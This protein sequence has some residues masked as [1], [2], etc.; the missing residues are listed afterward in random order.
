MPLTFDQ[1]QSAI[2]QL[3]KHFQTNLNLYHAPTYKEARV[4]LEFIDE[5]FVNLGWDVYSQERSTPQYPQ[6][7]VEPT[8]EST[9]DAAARAPDYLFRIGKETKL[10][11]EA[12]KPGVS[13]E[14]DTRPAYQ[15]RSYAFSAKL[16]LSI[17]TDL[18]RVGGL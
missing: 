15:V 18:R 6:V 13:I 3:V 2:N 12:K 8:L 4:R 1:A 11:V 16:P 9:G 17:L 10:F 7:E 14:S 5:M